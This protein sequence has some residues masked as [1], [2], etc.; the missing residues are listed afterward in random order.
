[1]NDSIINFEDT[2]VCLINKGPIIAT[3]NCA[4]NVAIAAP[5][6]P[7]YLIKIKFNNIFTIAPNP[8]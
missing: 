6:I 1:M 4:I 7:I 5:S 8:I 2:L 3:L